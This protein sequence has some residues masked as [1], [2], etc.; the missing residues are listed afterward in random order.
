ML[1][2]E[3]SQSKKPNFSTN[4]SAKRPK[5]ITK[6]P[7]VFEE[8]LVGPSACSV[9]LEPE[10]LVRHK[11]NQSQ[12]I[13]FSFLFQRGAQ[14]EFGE[15][16]KHLCPWK[17]RFVHVILILVVVVRIFPM[18][19]VENVQGSGA[20]LGTWEHIS[21]G[22]PLVIVVVAR[23][24]EDRRGAIMEIGEGGYQVPFLHIDQVI[25]ENP[26]FRVLLGRQHPEDTI[27][28][29]EAMD[30][31]AQKF[32]AKG[33]IVFPR[34]QFDSGVLQRYITRR[35]AP[36]NWHWE[37]VVFTVDTRGRD[38]DRGTVLRERSWGGRHWQ[39]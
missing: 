30:V 8:S 7:S 38:V 14:E 21:V 20:H 31:V 19:G 37:Y 28:A 27:L 22:V 24:I 12:Y 25:I 5:I 26:S 13:L 18:G 10:H 15:V 33:A 3:K 4:L 36:Q 35:W 39:G 1:H 23:E 17:Q 29:T 6:V 32:R 2:S 16:F 34:L 9:D 11:T